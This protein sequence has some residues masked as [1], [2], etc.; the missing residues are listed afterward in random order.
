MHP[1]LVSASY[2]GRIW[3]EPQL[4]LKMS[5]AKTDLEK[6][7]DA[8]IKE[9]RELTGE[10]IVIKATEEKPMLWDFDSISIVTPEM[11]KK[12]LAAELMFLVVTELIQFDE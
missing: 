1:L 3:I 2:K 6:A 11:S 10:E 7:T 9:L 5:E 8:T 12:R 4:N